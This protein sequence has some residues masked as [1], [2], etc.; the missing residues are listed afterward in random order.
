MRTFLRSTI[1]AVAVTGAVATVPASTGAATAP[2]GSRQV[3]V[4]MKGV[5][6]TGLRSAN[7][8]IAESALTGAIARSGG[9]VAQIMTAP[10]ALVVNATSSTIAALEGNPLVAGIYAN[11]IIHGPTVAHPS[12][13]VHH[14]AAKT[15][16][17]APGLCGTSSDP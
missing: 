16:H 10:S 14:A 8:R 4:L 11:G 5:A 6:T 13:T 1:A 2:A 9:S 15:G 7:L 3:I 12:I 17:V